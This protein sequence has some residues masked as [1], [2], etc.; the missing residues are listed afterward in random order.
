MGLVTDGS[1]IVG[2]GHL[3][4][5]TFVLT[6][7]SKERFGRSRDVGCYLGCDRGEV[8]PEITILSS[9]S[10]MRATPIFEAC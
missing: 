3:A 1:G 6:L 4:A 10:P 7:G 5:L 8:N 9:A 2:V